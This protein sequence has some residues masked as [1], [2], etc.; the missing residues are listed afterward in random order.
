[1]STATDVMNQTNDVMEEYPILTKENLPFKYHTS[2]QMRDAHSVQSLLCVKK[3]NTAIFGASGLQS[4]TRNG[5]SKNSLISS[6]LSSFDGETDTSDHSSA[7]SFQTTSLSNDSFGQNTLNPL[8]AANL[9]VTTPY[10]TPTTANNPNFICSGIVMI[11]HYYIV[12][13]IDMSM[14]IF[15]FVYFFSKAHQLQT[16]LVLQI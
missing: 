13:Y 2:N 5:L 1:M 6:S 12:F 16:H 8:A 7:A 14:C 9:F 4:L 10:D 3:Q 15:F 11:L